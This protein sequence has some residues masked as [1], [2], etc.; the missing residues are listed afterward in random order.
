MTE[1]RYL[2][3]GPLDVLAPGL[4][5]QAPGDIALNVTWAARYVRE[6]LNAHLNADANA[7]AFLAATPQ[8]AGAP[9]DLIQHEVRAALPAPPSPTEVRQL[10]TGKGVAAFAELF[11]T[12]R[13]KDPQPFSM[14]ALLDLQIWAGGPG[15]D[16]DG[17]IRKGIAL[18]RLEA[19]PNSS[20]VHFALANV[21][22]TRN[23]HELARKHF[24]E[25][26][27]LL[28]ADP[29]PSLDDSFKT[30]IRQRVEDALNRLPPD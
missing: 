15:R 8:Q 7:R 1:Y 14:A 6:F 4:L 25:T 27:R 9:A 5:G 29:D 3:Y 18:L 23:E 30:L 10:I 24:R 20:R 11:A 22:A 16:P 2:N 19:F 21:A 28:P 13:Q 17:S 26:L 12:L